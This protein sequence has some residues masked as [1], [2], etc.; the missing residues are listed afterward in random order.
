MSEMITSQAELPAAAFYVTARDTFMSGWGKS[1]GRDN[2]VIL[3]CETFA[4]AEGVSDYARS[5]SDMAD[6]RILWNK[7]SLSRA[8]SGYW[9]YSLFCRE[10]APAWYRE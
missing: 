5:R 8:K 7:P 3:P 2:L 6:V 1:K 9:T 10:E 4:E